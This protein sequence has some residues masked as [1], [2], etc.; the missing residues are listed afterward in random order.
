MKLRTSLFVVAVLALVA[1]SGSSDSTSRNRNGLLETTTIPGAVTT[2]IVG[3]TTLPAAATTTVP[4]AVTTSTV[5]AIGTTTTVAAPQVTASTGPAPIIPTPTSTSTTSAPTTTVPKVVAE[6]VAKT[7]SEIFPDKKRCAD[8]GMCRIGDTGP[9]G[10]IVFNI[11]D[12]GFV[13]PDAAI[14]NH[15]VEMAP[16]NNFTELSLSR[17]QCDGGLSNK[18]T[19]SLDVTNSL[20]KNCRLRQVNG[21]KLS[22]WSLPSATD[23]VPIIEFFQNPVEMTSEGKLNMAVRAT[24]D[25]IVKMKSTFFLTAIPNKC[26]EI[27]VDIFYPANPTLQFPVDPCYRPSHPGSEGYALAVRSFGPTTRP[28]AIG[29]PCKTGDVGPHGGITFPVQQGPGGAPI[30]KTAQFFEALTQQEFLTI[31]PWCGP[32]GQ[33]LRDLSSKVGF[34]QKNSEILRNDQWTGLPCDVL[35]TDFDQESFGYSGGFV[36]SV[37]EVRLLCNAAKTI[38]RLDATAQRQ[39]GVSGDKLGLGSPEKNRRMSRCPI[40]MVCKENIK[41][42]ASSRVVST[43]W[44]SSSSNGLPFAV[45]FNG[46]A[47]PQQPYVLVN[48]LFNDSRAISIQFYAFDAVLAK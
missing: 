34:G 26:R 28:C 39:C 25:S 10:G 4:A 33:P 23:L 19:F 7:F 27:P 14:V 12:T 22:D 13:T 11:S 36:P 8:G 9:G 15:F 20:I 3:A 2:T 30:G 41:G 31:G 18:T 24:I 37:E 17:F 45:A 38:K 48:Q 32:I 47:A 1:C 44:T 42:E 43:I 21:P 29:G 16:I 6:A 35:L 5:A 46:S 40:A